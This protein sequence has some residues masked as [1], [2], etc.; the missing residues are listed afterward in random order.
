VRLP[1]VIEF[2]WSVRDCT[3]ERRMASLGL[4][5]RTEV[6]EEKRSAR[7]RR[8]EEVVGCILAGDASMYEC[9]SEVGYPIGGFK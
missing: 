8:A 5:A 1:V 6:G 3:S 4:A 9:V 2:G 7:P